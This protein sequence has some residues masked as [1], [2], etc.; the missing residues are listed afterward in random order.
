MEQFRVRRIHDE[1][2]CLARAQAEIDV[3][4]GDGQ[5]A[6]VESADFVEHGLAHHRAGERDRAQVLRQLRAREITGFVAAFHQMRMTGDAADAD[7]HAGML[8]A[9]SVYS[10]F[11][12]TTPTSG[13]CAYSSIA[14]SQP[15]AITSVSLLSRTRYSPRA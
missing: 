9:L 2:A 14:L 6:F 11:A 3:V 13:R 8:D 12:P 15:R 4:E 7:D 10:S 1:V 5:F